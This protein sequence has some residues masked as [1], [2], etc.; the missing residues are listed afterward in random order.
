[1]AND[2]MPP[3]DNPVLNSH[4]ISPTNGAAGNVRRAFHD[5]LTMPEAIEAV[6]NMLAA[7]PN[8]KTQKS[9]IGAIAS[10]LMQ[11]PRS[12]AVRCADPANG[13]ARKTKFVPTVAEVV[14][15]CDPHIESMRDIA[16]FEARTERQLRERRQIENQNASE[17]QA[18][19][20]AVVARIRAEMAAAGLGKGAVGHSETPATVK[21]KL[22]LTDAQWDE[23]PDADPG[24]WQRLVANYRQA[25]E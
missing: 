21:A 9:Y 10:V 3:G 6:G 5:H 8:E 16:A 14:A 18:H 23:I 15:W 25:A 1:M 19:R 13:V 20:D 17:N 11:Y 4:S 22:G 2:L 24:H 12:V 7:Y